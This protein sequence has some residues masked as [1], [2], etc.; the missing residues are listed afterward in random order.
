MADDTRDAGAKAAAEPLDISLQHIALRWEL[1]RGPITAIEAMGA[2][3]HVVINLSI[4]NGPTLVYFATD[5]ARLARLLLVATN[6]VDEVTAPKTGAPALTA[7]LLDGSIGVAVGAHGMAVPAA[8]G[9]PIAWCADDDGDPRDGAN[10]S[11]CDGCGNLPGA[12]VEHARAGQV[13]RAARVVHRERRVSLSTSRRAVNS[14]LRRWNA[15][16]GDDE[17]SD[18]IPF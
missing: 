2:P 16:F 17:G 10:C 5:L 8:R 13:A 18:D 3:G 15:R 4:K 9:R 14:W 1:S 7:A 12:A 6:T 11:R